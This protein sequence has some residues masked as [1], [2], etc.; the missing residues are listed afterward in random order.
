[1][2]YTYFINGWEENKGYFLGFGFTEEELDRM[3]NGEKI[4]RGN[5]IFCIT[6]K[7]N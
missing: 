5:N 3:K 6:I 4:K 7:E 2:K 1:M